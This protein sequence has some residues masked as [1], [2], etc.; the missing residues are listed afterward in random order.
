MQSQA[1]RE[2][3]MVFRYPVHAGKL[4]E[5]RKS[6]KYHVVYVAFTVQDFCSFT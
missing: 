3:E 6:L 2:M 1:Q 4:G 5:E